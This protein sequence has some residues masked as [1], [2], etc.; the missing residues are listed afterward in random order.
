M[1]IELQQISNM[2]GWY[3]ERINQCW[4]NHAYP[5]LFYADIADLQLVCL[6][7]P[8]REQTASYLDQGILICLRQTWC[9]G[10]QLHVDTTAI[11]Q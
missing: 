6:R 1:R 4:L 9:H 2:L 8:I 5:L 11:G 7:I 3:V 10:T